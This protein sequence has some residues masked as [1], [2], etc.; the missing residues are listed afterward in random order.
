MCIRDKYVLEAGRLGVQD[1]LLKSSFSLKD[2][3]ARVVKYTGLPAKGAARAAPQ[4]HA[5]TL[6]PAPA[7][8]TAPAAAVLQPQGDVR[9]T[10]T[11][12]PAASNVPGQPALPQLLTREQ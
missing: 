2:L 6:A 10:A 12:A 11:A 7:T 4:T 1:Y 9:P 3:L 5:P 8:R